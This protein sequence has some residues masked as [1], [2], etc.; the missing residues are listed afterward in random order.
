MPRYVPKAA[1]RLFRAWGV[2][3]IPMIR[4]GARGPEALHR[5]GRP[6]SLASRPG[7]GEVR[8]AQRPCRPW[9]DRAG[10]LHPPS[11]RVHH[12]VAA[13]PRAL[14]SPSHPCP[15]CRLPTVGRDRQLLGPPVKLSCGRSGDTNGSSPISTAQRARRTVD[16]S[17]GSTI[18]S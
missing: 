15:G 7:Q 14:E 2:H 18:S 3:S 17:A 8:T 6:P 13:R 10:H 16:R 12:P 11:S 5:D 9:P 4:N 1:K